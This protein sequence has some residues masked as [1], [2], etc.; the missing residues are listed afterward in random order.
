MMENWRHTVST[1][2]SLFVGTSSILLVIL[3]AYFAQGT[4]A[5]EADEIYS[6]TQKR[7]DT[8]LYRGKCGLVGLGYCTRPDLLV[9]F[10]VSAILGMK[11]GKSVLGFRT[12]PTLVHPKDPDLYSLAD[13]VLVENAEAVDK[14]FRMHHADEEWVCISA[15]GRRW[16]ATRT[17]NR[18]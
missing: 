10:D 17:A 14:V 16:F 11:P 5:R 1:N 4:R 2:V 12:S 7:F 3:Y 8:A 9:R 18:I 13:M 15:S 6:T